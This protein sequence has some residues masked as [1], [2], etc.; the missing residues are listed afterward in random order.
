MINFRSITED[1]FEYLEKSICICNSEQE[2]K[3]MAKNMSANSPYPVYFFETN[4]SG[5]KLYE[6][7]HTEA[8]EVNMSRYDSIGVITNSLK[9]S[10]KDMEKT[11]RQI[12]SVFGKSDCTK[13]E[14]VAAM[15]VILPDFHHVETGKSLD[16]KM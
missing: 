3:E 10:F 12:E 1:F 2:A 6:E 5:E 13:E 8:D 16:Q 14:V 15:S 7:F 11:M 9:P 4:T